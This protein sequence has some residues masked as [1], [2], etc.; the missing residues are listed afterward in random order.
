M[1]MTESYNQ[2]LT[3]AEAQL[4]KLVV[5]RAEIDRKIHRLT[6]LIKHL[7]AMS[8]VDADVGLAPLIDHE[9]RGLSSGIKSVLRQSRK[10]HTASDV[11]R[12]LNEVG[13]DLSTYANAS[14]VINTVLNRLHKQGLVEKKDSDGTP[15]YLWK[16]DLRERVKKAWV[17][18]TKNI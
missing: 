4:E 15:T 11:R 3:D 14:S 18:G 6:Q 7:A 5:D 1:Q 12:L 8:G 16:S 10:G 2:A 13:Y 17:E 9:N